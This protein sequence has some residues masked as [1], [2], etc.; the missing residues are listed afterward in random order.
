MELDQDQVSAIVVFA[1]LISGTLLFW[2]FRLAFALAGI[3]ALMAL[4]L[5]TTERLN[6]F[7]GLEIILFLVG[8]MTVIGYLEERRFFEHI[9]EKLI[10]GVG[11]NP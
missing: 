1:G 4:G 11:I 2:K 7:A 9:L 5:L 8:M 3:G 6:E 10:K